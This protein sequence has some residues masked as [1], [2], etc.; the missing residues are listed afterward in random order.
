MPF[1]CSYRSLHLTIP[2]KP[3]QANP[4]SP[5]KHHPG[6]P[7]TQITNKHMH[8]QAKK[9]LLGKQTRN[10]EKKL[11]LTN[12]HSPSLK[13]QPTRRPPINTE[14]RVKAPITLHAFPVMILTVNTITTIITT[15]PALKETVAIPGDTNLSLPL[16]TLTRYTADTYPFQPS[17]KRTA[18]TQY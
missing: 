12:A 9:Q 17:T 13:H 18:D 3:H 5:P 8:S 10:K 11:L 6:P 15:N 16:H 14:V 1:S 4:T 7:E 2:T